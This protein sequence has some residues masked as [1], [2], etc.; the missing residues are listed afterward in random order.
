MDE[1]INNFI[2]VCFELGKEIAC[3]ENLTSKEEEFLESLAT[4]VK[5][6]VNK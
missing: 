6:Y 1:N 5:K 3:K 4:I 2:K